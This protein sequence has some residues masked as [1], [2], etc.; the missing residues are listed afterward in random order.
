ARR[1]EGHPLSALPVHRLALEPR[2]SAIANHEYGWIWPERPPALKESAWR[3][4]APHAGLQVRGLADQQRLIDMA[5]PVDAWRRRSNG[6]I[7]ACLFRFE[8]SRPPVMPSQAVLKAL[9]LACLGDAAENEVR[10]ALIEPPQAFLQ[11]FLAASNGGA[12]A[13]AN[14]GAWGRLLAWRSMSAMVGSVGGSFD[15]VIAAAKQCSWLEFW[16][17]SW[18]E[19]VAWDLG[20]AAFRHDNGTAAVLAATDTD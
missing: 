7:E 18:F 15:Q 19:D 20:L 2:L 9:G 3:G 5:A 10:A 12:Y 6:K 14:Q 16:A 17:P 1:A 13:G 4:P 11:L 8:P